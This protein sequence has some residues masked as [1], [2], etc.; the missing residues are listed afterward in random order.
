VAVRLLDYIIT[1]AKSRHLKRL[2]ALD[3]S[4][5]AWP[6][7]RVA[8]LDGAFTAEHCREWSNLHGMH[9]EVVVRPPG[10][11][12]F[13][14]LPRRPGR[15][16]APRVHAGPLCSLPCRHGLPGSAGRQSQSDPRNE[17]LHKLEGQVGFIVYARRWAVKRFFAWINRNPRLAKDV[18]ATIASAESFLYAASAIL[19]L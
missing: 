15:C 8:V 1:E 11:R 12:G 19:L 2:P 9:H 7:L 6:S 3:T 10:Q 17:I 18:E 16:C 14:V 4:K 13:T 5:V